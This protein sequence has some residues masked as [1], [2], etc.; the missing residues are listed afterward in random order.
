M[1]YWTER[2]PVP[3]PRAR[4]PDGWHYDANRVPMPPPGL[5]EVVDYNASG[6]ESDG[7]L[8]DFLDELDANRAVAGGDANQAAEEV[9]EV[10]EPDAND[11]V[12]E[13][14]MEEDELE[15]QESADFCRAI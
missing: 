13:L 15:E 4:L 8:G 3:W 1:W 14:P 7:E 9:E 11:D 10:Q 6:S 12:G 5:T 2:M